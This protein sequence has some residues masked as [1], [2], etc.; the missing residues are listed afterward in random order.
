MGYV[1]ELIH[2]PRPDVKATT[3]VAWTG[4]RGIVSLATALALPLKTTT[5]HDFP[6]REFIIFFSFVVILATLV[7]Q[8]LSLGP[9]IRWLGLRADSHMADE[10]AAARLAAAR[11]ALVALARFSNDTSIDP[12]VLHWLRADYEHRIANLHDRSSE[13]ERSR[14]LDGSGKLLAVRDR[15]ADAQLRKLRLTAV[16]AERHQIIEMRTRSGS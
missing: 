16:A 11:A 3:V 1:P 4:M 9:L 10:E 7:L 12:D 5:G 6:G 14:K 8:G 2:K 15:S 13:L